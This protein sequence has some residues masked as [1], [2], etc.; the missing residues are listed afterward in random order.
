MGRLVLGPEPESATRRKPDP[1]R[2]DAGTATTLLAALLAV[3]SAFYLPAS[4][5]DLIHAAVR[6]VEVGQ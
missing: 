6:V 3:I 5:L 1:E 4:L 2:L